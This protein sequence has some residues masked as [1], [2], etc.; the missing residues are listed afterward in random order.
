MRNKKSKE[1]IQQNKNR[2]PEKKETKMK[3]ENKSFPS[4]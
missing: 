2:D 3:L 1:K 4:K